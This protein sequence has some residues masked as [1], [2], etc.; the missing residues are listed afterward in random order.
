MGSGKIAVSR[1]FEVRI[2]TENLRL[3]RRTRAFTLRKT[4]IS[5]LSRMLHACERESAAGFRGCARKFFCYAAPPSRA[6]R[7]L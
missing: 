7:D 1:S 5:Y 6:A 3:L 2:S 4:Q